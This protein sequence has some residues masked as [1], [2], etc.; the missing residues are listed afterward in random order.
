MSSSSTEQ[1]AGLVDVEMPQMG[2]SVSEG[3]LVAW[4][5]SVGDEVAYEETICDIAT[6][7]IDIECPSP[8]AGVVAELL[9]EPDQTVPVGTV[10]ARIRTAGGGDAA[11]SRAGD[12]ESVAAAEETQEEALRAEVPGEPPAPPDPAPGPPHPSPPD[13]GP[14]TPPA[15]D[16]VPPPQPNPQPPVIEQPGGAFVS[17]VVRRIAAEHGID[18]ATVEGSGR[19]GRVTKRDMLRALR[20]REAAAAAAEPP[21]HIESPYREEPVAHNGHGGHNGHGVR[22]G[23]ARGV[24]PSTPARPRRRRPANR[25]R[26]RRRRRPRMSR[27]S[28]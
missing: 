9:V 6:D 17:P 11:P 26:Q 24:A 18:P 12:P 1:Q 8:A 5:K 2:V 23:G 25:C 20:E 10:L 27:A 3:T 22:R 16:P 19:R 14:P 4:H 7:K 21:M 13:P 15:P 28:R